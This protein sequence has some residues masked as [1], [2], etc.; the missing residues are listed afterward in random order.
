MARVTCTTE[1]FTDNWIEFSETWTRRD[2]QEL[3]QA[4]VESVL[5]CLRRKATACHIILSD[6][7]VIDDVE[8]LTDDGLSN[9]DL[10][11]WGFV[12]GSLFRLTGALQSLG[13]FSVRVSSDS[14]ARMK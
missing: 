6:G 4:D 1:G 14:V 5:A 12:L 9:A 3:D 8:M 10:Q 2:R 11:V 13:N 7:S